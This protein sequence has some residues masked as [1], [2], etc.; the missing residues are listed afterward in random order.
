M[1]SCLKWLAN[2]KTALVPVLIAGF[3]EECFDSMRPGL[4][5]FG[6]DLRFSTNLSRKL[7]NY[8]MIILPTN[9]DLFD[10]SIVSDLKNFI[11]E[12]GSIATFHFPD[13]NNSFYFP[14]NQILSRFG[15]A[16]TFC[17]TAQQPFIIS[18]CKDFETVY[19]HHFIPQIEK[20][21]QIITSDTPEDSPELCSTAIG[22][23]YMNYGATKSQ[24][25]QLTDISEMCIGYLKK[26]G[27]QIF[28]K[29]FTANY[30]LSGILLDIFPK[31]P[32]EA[33][34][35]FPGY[36]LFPGQ[37]G[38]VELADFSMKLNI[39]NETWT[40]TGLYLP[41]GKVSIVECDPSDFLNLQIGAHHESLALKQPPWKRWPSIV[42]AFSLNKDTTDVVSPF[43]GPVYIAT[44]QLQS[45][46]KTLDFTFKGFVKYPRVVY[47]DPSIWESTKDIDVP[48]GEI[49]CENVIFTLPTSYMK[50]LDFD[51]IFDVIGKLIREIATF[52]SYEINDPLRV[53][54][55]I[56]LPE[57]APGC[58]YPIVFPIS[59]I[60]QILGSIDKPNASLL[61]LSNL[62]GIFMIREGCFDSVIET[63][64]ATLASAVAF[65]KLY[66]DFNPMPITLKTQQLFFE[67]WNIYNSGNGDI[68]QKTLKKYQNKDYEIVG[69]PEDTWLD[70]VQ[71]LCKNG[72]MD[73]TYFLQQARPIP[74]N[75]SISCHNFPRYEEK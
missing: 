10:D 65:S 51:K 9:F 4:Q 56:D 23:Q 25:Q 42:F 16:Y 7:S 26:S 44:S 73:Y 63:T 2:Q 49:Q 66:K 54:F 48:I 41:A 62:I 47:G 50:D 45:G 55:D 6:F 24:I 64:L 27:S 30:L 15:L 53:V 59:E 60:T 32:P 61:T 58:G 19:S 5:S 29:S 40:S 71:E 8:K 70:F 11:K 46:Q 22:I 13:N 75:V 38:D 1:K 67:L 52:L 31:L 35:P 74:L 21:K 34:T 14:I 18:L 12:G 33:V 72:K 20:L 28:D 68:I 3:P 43:G 69:V 37:C 39:S 36:E 17:K 57:D